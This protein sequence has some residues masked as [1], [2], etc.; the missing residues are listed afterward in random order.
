MGLQQ[1]FSKFHNTIALSRE[2]DAY[3][4]SREKDDSLL[5]EIRTAMKNAGYPLLRTF[6]QGSHSHGVN[7]GVIP[8]NGEDFDIDRA[9]II[10]EDDAPCDPLAV[11][12]VVKN[13]MDNRR[14][15]N[16]TIKMPC[17][18]A[19]YAS[20]PIHL[21]YPI[22]KQTDDHDL[23]LAIGRENSEGEWDL[24]DPEG[25]R[26]WI[27]SRKDYASFFA[28]DLTDEEFQQFRRLVRYMK[29]W[30]DVQ[31]P[32]S[33]RKYIYSIGLTL[34]IREC[35]CSSINVTGPDNDLESLTRTIDKILKI[36]Y[37]TGRGVDKFDIQVLLPVAP[38]RDVFDKHGV[39][40][41][42]TF[43]KKLSMLLVKLN[44]AEK[45]ESLKK[46]CELL[47]KQ[48]GSDFLVPEEKIDDY[49]LTTTSIAGISGHSHGA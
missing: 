24:N 28:D 13:V 44:D 3:K 34:M 11:K 18:T 40:V 12:R 4:N 22:Y 7:T 23:Y 1:Q 47:A 43:H 27:C 45:E 2:D 30:R 14:F 48:F 41:G 9:L 20:T 5:N 25:L 10:D 26:K 42:T 21:D 33:M 15:K 49:N 46:Q 39:T 16:A 37:F 36:G 31:F 17:V 29:R 19:D 6:L 8:I 32:E 35:F 38:S